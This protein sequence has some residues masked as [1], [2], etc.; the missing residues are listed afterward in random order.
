MLGRMIVGGRGASKPAT[1]PAK[2]SVPRLAETYPRNRLFRVLDAACRRRVAWLAA[3]A[4]AGKTS[5]VAT[6]LSSRRLPA[7]WYNVDTRD[8]DVAHLFHYL[9]LAAG[10]ASRRKKLDLPEF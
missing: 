4:G 2:I 1:T 6:Y 9:A 7:L 8:A 5:L 3:P 10:Y